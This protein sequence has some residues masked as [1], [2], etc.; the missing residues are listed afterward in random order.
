MQKYK[1][2]DFAK[3]AKKAEVTDEALNDALAEMERGLLGDRLGANIYKKRISIKG[4][5]K[6]GGARTLLVF[7]E[8]ESRSRGKK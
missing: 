4:R 3:W 6:S 2:P 7:K 5:G 1:L 8:S